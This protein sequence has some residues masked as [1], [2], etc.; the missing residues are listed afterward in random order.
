MMTDPDDAPRQAKP[1]P[2]NLEIMGVEELR[3]Y[4]DALEKE[5]ERVRRTIAAKTD[6]RGAADKLFKF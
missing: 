3:D 6:F 2:R 5:A 1:Q 4:L